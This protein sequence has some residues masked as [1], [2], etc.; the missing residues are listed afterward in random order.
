MKVMVGTVK[1]IFNDFYGSYRSKWLADMQDTLIKELG[2]DTKNKE[3][4]RDIKAKPDA[5]SINFETW[6]ILMYNI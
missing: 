3:L 5:Y 1:T 6:K 2:F 4:I